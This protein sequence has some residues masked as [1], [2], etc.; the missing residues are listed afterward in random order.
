MLHKKTA[1]YDARCPM[2]GRWVP[3]EIETVPT[4]LAHGFNGA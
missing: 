2:C 3:I 1:D 4:G